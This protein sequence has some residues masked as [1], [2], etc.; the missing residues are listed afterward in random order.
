MR[1]REE[2]L[3]GLECCFRVGSLVGEDCDNC[4]YN[5]LIAKECDKELFEDV[6]RALTRPELFIRESEVLESRRKTRNG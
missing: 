1:S 2:I 5:N 6:K 3:K 4:P